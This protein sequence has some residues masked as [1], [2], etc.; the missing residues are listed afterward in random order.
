MSEREEWRRRVALY[1]AVLVTMFPS[2]FCMYHLH[3]DIDLVKRH[4]YD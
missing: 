2:T 4:E 3:N 1:N